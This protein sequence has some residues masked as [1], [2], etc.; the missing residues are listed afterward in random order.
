MDAIRRGLACLL[1]CL[2][3]SAVAAPA[4]HG[5]WRAPCR[6]DG[7]GPKCTFWKAKATFI[8]DGDTIK[9]V[10]ADDPTRTVQL[11][12]FTGINAMELH[13][14][15][16]FAS[17]RRGD[18]HGLDAAAFVE[19]AVKRSRWRIRL[20]A[21]HASSRSGGRHRLRR[22]V[23]VKVRGHWRDLAKLELQA[24]LALWLPN[25]DEWAHNGEYHRLA[26]AAMLVQRGLYDPDGCGVG[27]DQDL[28]LTL[29]VNWDADGNDE[30]ALN[31]EWVDI[32]NGGIRPLSL[33]GW[34]FR[35][36]WLRYSAHRLPGYEFPPG[37]V[38]PAGGSVRL[39]MGCGAN[40]PTDL[41]WCQRESVFENVTS[42]GRGL[43][44]GG[45]LFDPQ[46]DLRASTNYP[47]VVACVD[48][49]AGKV[50]VSVHP[51]TPESITIA[52]VSQA[53]VDLVDHDLKLSLPGHPDTF[54]FGYPF[55]PGTILGPGER[56]RVVP[57]GPTPESR[58]VR[59]LHRGTYVLSDGRGVV[60]L[61]T[62]TDLVT[63]CYDWGR[64]S[65]RC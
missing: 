65:G 6:G 59:N 38:V 19:R 22:S 57:G 52:N 23:W 27:P 37:T 17:R 51:T 11:I 46:G 2:A 48:P 61:R 55:G 63:D 43:G 50:Q 54:I 12:R 44:D 35:D 29:S 15:S 64:D 42:N 25:G 24:G 56:M 31:G 9:A 39:H 4:A 3:V 5:S 47:C 7:T 34:W 8:A 53:P 49:L 18:C 40:T 58:L 36:S 28:P 26:A 16:K 33:R 13:R 45:Y 14:Y 32:R 60:S 30:A 10:L 62:M 20:A 21:Q 1:A 41:H